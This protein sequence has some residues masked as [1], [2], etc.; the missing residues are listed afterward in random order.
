MPTFTLQLIKD[1]ADYEAVLERISLLFD[2]SPQ[3]REGEE[4]KTLLL[5]VD[6]YQQ[7]EHLLP[8]AEPMEVLKFMMQQRALSL[9]DIAPYV[10]GEQ[11]ANQIL[12]GQREL[13]P[14]ISKGIL[15]ICIYLPTH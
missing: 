4:L 1:Q 13:T 8:E 2:A 7:R 3:S 12:S 6:S 10:E 11:I 9:Q 14:Q 5:G 15:S